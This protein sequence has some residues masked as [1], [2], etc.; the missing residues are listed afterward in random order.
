MSSAFTAIDL[1]KL[2][3]VNVIN[4]PDFETI[5]GELKARLTLLMPE[6]FPVLELE[7]E[8]LVKVL[9][10]WAYRE[11]MVRQE[12]DDAARSNMLAYATGAPLDHLAAFY[13]VIRLIDQ[14]ADP[15]AV[16]PVPE[17]LESDDRLRTRVQLALEG[18]TTAGSRGSYAFHALSASTEVRD[19]SVIS[20]SPGEVTVTVLSNQGDGTPSQELL[21]SVEEAL[22]DEDVRPL[23]D[24]VVVQPSAIGNYTVAAELYVYPGPDVALVEAASRAAVEKYIAAQHRI[25]RDI[26]RSGL[27]AALHQEGVQRV[28]LASPLADILVGVEATMFCINV[29][30]NVVVLDV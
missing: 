23:T 5:L 24:I 26:S 19:V 9:Q 15:D 27:M 1:A 3:P 7:S 12:V 28:F 17:I 10:V 14:E 13:G 25:G 6:L 8:P 20:K 22:N 21:T 18:F 29:G 2:P 11:M 4:Q 30:L 16:P